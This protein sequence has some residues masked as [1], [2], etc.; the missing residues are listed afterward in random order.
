MLICRWNSLK[1]VA[2]A[3]AALGLLLSARADTPT[4]ALT[5][6]DMESCWG[7]LEKDEASAA[8]ALLKLSASPKATIPFLKEKLKPLSIDP[9]RIQK[10]LIDLDSKNDETWKS[11]FEELDYFD[12]RLQFELEAL[13]KMV[14][15]TPARQRLVAVLSNHKLDYLEGKIVT[16]SSHQGKD[17]LFYNFVVD[18]G[19]FWAEHR[20]SQ[21]NTQQWG[22]S[23]KKWTRAV[24]A[25]ILLEHINTKEAAD[26][27]KDLAKGNQDAQPTKIAKESLKKMTASKG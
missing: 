4:P 6:K 20:V 18:N 10:L 25:I 27:L 19:S 1:W 22:T 14:E 8:R 2:F 13:M 24:R 3:F 5:Q 17:G 16:L 11:A 12:P 26:I 7:D 23:K 21:L 15:T 9:L